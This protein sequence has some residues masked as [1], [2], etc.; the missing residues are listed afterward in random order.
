MRLVQLEQVTPAA[1]TISTTRSYW[2]AVM[3][4]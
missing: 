1:A 3:T 2:P 4:T